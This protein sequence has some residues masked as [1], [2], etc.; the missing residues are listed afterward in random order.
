MN[1]VGMSK[2]ELA[3]EYDV[4]YT[5]IDRLAKGH[6]WKHL[7]LVEWKKENSHAKLAVTHTSQ[8]A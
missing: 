3:K 7:E 4:R 6:S 5:T 1:A 2:N 8:T